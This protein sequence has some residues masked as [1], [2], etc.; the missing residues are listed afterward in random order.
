[1]T[2]QEKIELARKGLD[3]VHAAI[4]KAMDGDTSDLLT[5]EYILEL[6]KG[7]A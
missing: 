3:Y 2:E 7:E 6:M 5:A 4:R 1:M